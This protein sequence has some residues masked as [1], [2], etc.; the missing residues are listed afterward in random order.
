M[1]APAAVP[2]TGLE[3]RAKFLFGFSNLKQHLDQCEK[4]LNLFIAASSTSFRLLRE[5]VLVRA[6]TR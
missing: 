1:T 6:E 2:P 5:I 3:H 4:E